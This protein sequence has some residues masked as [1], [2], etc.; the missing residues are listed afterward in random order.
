MPIDTPLL[1]SFDKEPTESTNAVILDD[2]NKPP[3]QNFPQLPSGQVTPFQRLSPNFQLINESWTD[4]LNG[5]PASIA[6]GPDVSASDPQRSD[7]EVQAVNLS[8]GSQPLDLEWFDNLDVQIP[9][10]MTSTFS[11]IPQSLG[12]YDEYQVAKKE[13]PEQ[14]DSPPSGPE[15]VSGVFESSYSTANEDVSAF[16]DR[17][18]S[19]EDAPFME[20]NDMSPGSS[21][22]NLSHII[23]NAG[24]F[25]VGQ[26]MQQPAS[27]SI[28]GKVRN[29]TLAQRGL[30]RHTP[31]SLQ[32]V[33]TARKR[34]Q[35]NA[36][37]SI[38][39][40]QLPKPLQIVQEDGQ[41]GSISSADFVS[42]PR[43]A[44]RKGPLSIVGRA[45]A[46]MRRKNKDTCVQCRLNKR[47]VCLLQLNL[48]NFHRSPVADFELV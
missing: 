47:K 29:I 43:G 30:T 41:G 8:A 14:S 44:R 12:L 21:V 3:T 28:P 38:D 7:G 23:P 26:G 48:E 1:Y 19:E 5:P 25:L 20:W 10:D 9:A 40:P 45:N 24:A 15:D 27:P 17:Q 16:A 4:T 22:S 18:L 11:V 37:G 6:Q 2:S 33:T 42:P 39:Q 34:K 13:S 32:P 36:A 31:L 46:G 35:R